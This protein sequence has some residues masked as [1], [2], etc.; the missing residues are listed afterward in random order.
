MYIKDN[1]E[2]KTFSVFFSL[3]ATN[4]CAKEIKEIERRQLRVEHCIIQNH[5][6]PN[7]QCI[8]RGSPG[9]REK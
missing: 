5:S 1:F 2:Q 4:W 6:T 7:P 8:Q 3:A 9:K